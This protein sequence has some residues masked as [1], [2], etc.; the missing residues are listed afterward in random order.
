MKPYVRPGSWKASVAR[1]ATI[2]LCAACGNASTSDLGT[3]GGAPDG[4]ASEGGRPPDGQAFDGGGSGN[5][6]APGADAG[7]QGDDGGTSLGL[8][9]EGA[10]LVDQGKTVRLLGVSH[11]GT[12]YQCVGG[13]AIFEGPSDGTLVPPMKAWNINAIRIPLNEDCWLGINGVSPMVGGAAYQTAI[14][15]F[16][17][18]LREKGLYVIV[19]LHWSAPGGTLAMSQQPMADSDHAP[20]FWQSVATAL[21]SDLGVVFDLYNEPYP[22]N[23]QDTT[24]A[25][26]CWRDGTCPSVSFPVAGMQSLVDTVRGTGAKNVILL[27]GVQYA[28]ALSQWLAYKPMDPLSNLVA[29]AHVYQAQSCSS[30]SCYDMT[31]GKVAAQVPVIT[32][33]LG[34]NDCAHGFVDS[35]FAWA[36]PL[37]ISYLGWAWNVQD[38]KRFP[39]LITDYMGTASAFGEGFK[40][41]LPTQ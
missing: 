32:G 12:E 36:D 30:T 26:T 1:A 20:A 25:W 8:H 5:D 37:G 17:K 27:G 33:E 14:T 35:Y 21:Q 40:A 28:N 16:V 39:A 24:A 41:H 22:D 15:A 23:N 29:G 10:H 6:A 2:A 7:G 31:I 18:M 38:C 4:I 19:D 9:V 11:S 13:N 3:D 34:E